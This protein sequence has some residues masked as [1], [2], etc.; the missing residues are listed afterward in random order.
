MGWSA[1]RRI[2]LRT[3][4]PITRVRLNEAR[5]RKN[6][7]CRRRT[8]L[9][10]RVKNARKIVVSTLVNIR[11]KKTKVSPPPPVTARQETLKGSTVTVTPR[12]E[13]DLE[14][15]SHKQALLRVAS[16]HNPHKEVGKIAPLASSSSPRTELP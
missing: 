4:A 11:R 13:L 8:P 15:S 12:T 1:C 5:R 14:G 3:N 7:G 2:R 9:G 6:V 10:C 16:Q